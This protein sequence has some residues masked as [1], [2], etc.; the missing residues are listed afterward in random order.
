MSQENV[1]VVRR[2]FGAFAAGGV[3]AA[4]AFVRPDAVVYPFPEWVEES[5]YRDHDGF[6]RVIAVW[7]DN[8]D[9]FKLEVCEIREVGDRVLM[10]GETAG[11]IK[12][13]GVPIRQ[14]LGA[15]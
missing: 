8:F 13:S 3:E 10:L 7:T 9:N 14:P 4:L 5:E 2:F 6:R 15:V 11:R 1:E 12:S